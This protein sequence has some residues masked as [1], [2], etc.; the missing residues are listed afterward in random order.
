[1]FNT[2][3]SLPS[4]VQREVATKSLV[5]HPNLPSHT[6]TQQLEETCAL[7]YYA[8]QDVF[9]NPSDEEMDFDVNT[10][11]QQMPDSPLSPALIPTNRP[12][13]NQSLPP[14]L[15]QTLLDPQTFNQELPLIGKRA[16]A[17]L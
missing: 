15:P 14:I 5:E 16:L 9:N 1:L 8:V 17:C 7:R 11:K 10:T 3:E 4:P 6:Y 2:P 13:T 12:C